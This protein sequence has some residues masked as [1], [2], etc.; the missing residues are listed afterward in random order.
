MGPD[1]AGPDWRMAKILESLMYLQREAATNGKG[2]Q[3]VLHKVALLEQ[4]MAHLVETFGARV[5]SVERQV[6]DVGSRMTGIESR[7]DLRITAIEHDNARRFTVL[8]GRLNKMDLVDAQRVGMATGAKWLWGVL[9]ATGA[10]VMGAF[11]WIVAYWPG[12]K[13]P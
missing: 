9:G 8:E 4:S 2:V 5:A 6:A 7:G 13:V 12:G 11:A 10:F 1:E 3:D